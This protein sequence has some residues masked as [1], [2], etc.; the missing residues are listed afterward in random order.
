[1]F[2]KIKTSVAPSR[3][4]MCTRCSVLEINPAYFK[5]G[6]PHR[7]SLIGNRPNV[8]KIDIIWTQFL[9]WNLNHP[10][11]LQSDLWVVFGLKWIMNVRDVVLRWLH[12]VLFCDGSMC[13]AEMDACGVSHRS[14]TPHACCDG[15]MCCAEMAACG[16]VLRWLHV[17]L[18]WDGCMWCCAAMAACGVVLRWL[19]VLCWDGCMWCCADMAACGVVLRWLHVVLCWDCC[20]W[21]CA[22]MAMSGVWAR[23]DMSSVWGVTCS[24]PGWQWSE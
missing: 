4:Q 21:C 20:M 10:I 22:G 5:Q 3:F 8:S 13:C 17:V 12:V 2:T 24:C 15:C 18:C 23:M 14:T 19:H 9:D 11:E 7:S 16:V 6:T 1:M